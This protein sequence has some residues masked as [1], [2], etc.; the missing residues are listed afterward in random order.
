MAL[1]GEKYGDK[2]RVDQRSETFPPN[3]AAARHDACYRR[4][5]VIKDFERGKRCRPAAAVEAITGET[6]SATLEK[7]H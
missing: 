5:W 1:F 7:D 2:V 4:N 3:S 6:R